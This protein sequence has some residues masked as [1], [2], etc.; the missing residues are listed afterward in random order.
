MNNYIL[1]IFDTNKIITEEVIRNANGLK[2]KFCD[3]ITLDELLK[4]KNCLLNYK[5][6]IDCTTKKEFYQAQKMMKNGVEYT[7]NKINYIKTSTNKFL[8]TGPN[9]SRLTAMQFNQS[10]EIMINFQKDFNEYIT[11]INFIISKIPETRNKINFDKAIQNDGIDIT[12]ELHKKINTKNY[13]L[14]KQLPK[15]KETNTE[16]IT[17]DDIIIL[18]KL[19]EIIEFIK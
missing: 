2:Y 15:E 5:G 10:K 19:K 13:K 6:V 16:Y 14:V 11:V 8:S 17:Y 18:N 9:I 4:N 1:I 3:I 7:E 12:S